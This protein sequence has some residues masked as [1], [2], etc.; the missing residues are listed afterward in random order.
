MDALDGEEGGLHAQPDAYRRKDL[1]PGDF[2]K[3]GA[4]AEGVEKAGADAEEN[5]GDDEEGPAA[6]DIN[7]PRGAFGFVT[8]H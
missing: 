6:L 4:R 7:K 1:E 5:R 8:T 2:G 3:R